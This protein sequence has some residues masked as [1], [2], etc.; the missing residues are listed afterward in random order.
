MDTNAGTPT[1]YMQRVKT[2]TEVLIPL[3]RHLRA[4][5]GEAEANALVYPVLRDYMRNWIAEF[6]S[7]ESDNPIENFQKTDEKLQTMYEGD[8]AYDILNNDDEKLDLN[9]TSC[10]YADF[11]RRLGEP[12]LGEILV[13]EADDHIAD[14]SA[15]NV[16]MSRA[17]TLMK[18]GTHCPF[19]YRFSAAKPGE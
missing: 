5:L 17:D 19:R 8:I 7:K 4:E 9:V 12:E 18:G 10:L 16:E 3:L 15:P 11:F 13:C 14:L 6:A 1:L 2:Q